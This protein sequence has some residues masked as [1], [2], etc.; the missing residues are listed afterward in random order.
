MGP[1]T[2]VDGKR[3]HR[4]RWRRQS[5]PLQWGRRLLSTES[6]HAGHAGAA[7]RRASMGPP[8]VVDG[9]ACPEL[10]RVERLE[11]SMGPPTVVDGKRCGPRESSSGTRGFNRSEEHTSELQS[12]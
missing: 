9:K 12:L 7:L 4:R 10:H 11:A 1:P 3:L 5:T 2:V 8:T 6:R